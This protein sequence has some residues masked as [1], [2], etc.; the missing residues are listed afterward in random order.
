MDLASR[1]YILVLDSSGSMTEKDGMSKSRWERIKE[2]TG[3]I[4]NKLVELDDDGITVY[5]F[6][7]SF[8]KFENVKDDSSVKAIFAKDPIGST[9]LAPVLTDIFK[10]FFAKR[11]KALTV[12]VITDGAANDPKDICREII[13]ATKK[14]EADEELSLEFLQIGKDTSAKEFLRKLDDDLQG[15]G[16]KFD[17]VDTKTMDDLENSTIEEII[18]ASIND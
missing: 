14:M 16:A 11:T 4:V 7:S 15:M 12:F 9:T 5:R 6:A 3:A 17:I 10:D 2:T 1:D 13:S 18:I 8:N